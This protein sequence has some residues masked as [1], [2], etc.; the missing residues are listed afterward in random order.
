METIIKHSSQ[1]TKIPLIHISLNDYTGW[2]ASCD[3]YV[4]TK[5][6]TQSTIKALRAAGYNIQKSNDIYKIINDNG[7]TWMREDK[8][9]FSATLGRNGYL[10]QYHEDLIS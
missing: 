10:V 2:A 8:P 5:K 6:E 4:W 3:K 1:I 9:L 7:Y